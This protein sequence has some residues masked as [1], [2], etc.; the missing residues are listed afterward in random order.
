[1]EIVGNVR[2]HPVV[3]GK[4]PASLAA[5]AVYLASILLNSRKTQM[6]V[7]STVGQTDVAIR[8]A[9]SALVRALDIYVIM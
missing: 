4:S 5:A 6:E 7:G 3:S 8:N 1:S 9:Y 2:E